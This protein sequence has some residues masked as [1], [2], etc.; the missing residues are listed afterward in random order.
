[1]TEAPVIEPQAG[2]MR[3]TMHRVVRLGFGCLC[4]VPNAS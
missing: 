3:D 1:M 2:K 4:S